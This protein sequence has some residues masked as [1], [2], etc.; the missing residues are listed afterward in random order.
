MGRSL[1]EQRSRHQLPHATEP[2]NSPHFFPLQQLRSSLHDCPVDMQ[3]QRPPKQMLLQHSELTEQFA[4]SAL[5]TGVI[6]QQPE[7]HG[8]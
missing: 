2:E 3:R 7:A 1:F 5:H 8:W 4:P 6:A